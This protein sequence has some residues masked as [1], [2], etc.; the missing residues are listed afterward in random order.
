MIT[1]MHSNTS[2][3]CSL[4]DRLLHNLLFI[5]G[6]TLL[7]PR[8]GIHTMDYIYTTNHRLYISTEEAWGLRLL[9]CVAAIPVSVSPR[10]LDESWKWIYWSQTKNGMYQLSFMLCCIYHTT[11]SVVA[12]IRFSSPRQTH[13]GKCLYMCKEWG[14]LCSIN[15]ELNIFISQIK[16]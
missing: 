1:R 4:E 11:V 13:W 2:F 5:T 16:H 6:L 8:I 3:T 10:F 12:V 9:D 15:T 14:K 7:Y